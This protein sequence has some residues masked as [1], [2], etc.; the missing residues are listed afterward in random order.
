MENNQ[1][2]D[3]FIEESQEHIENLNS[4][5]LLLENDPENRQ[6]IDEI[7]RSAHTLKGMAATMGFE[8]MNKL[9][10]KME[11]VLQEVKNGQLHISHAIMDIL[12]KCVDTLSEMLDSISQTGEDNVPIEELIFLLSGVSSK[13]GN[14]EN[15][16]QK[17]NNASGSDTLL[18]V[19]E[20]DIIREAAKD[21]YKAYKITVHID[22]GCVMKSARAFIIFN[23]LDEIGDIINSSP[24]V[25]DIE[26]EKFEDSF[27]VHIITK[28]DKESIEKRLLSIAEVNNV[29]VELINIDLNKEGERFVKEVSSSQSQSFENI[30]KSQ[31]NNKTSKSV[32]V[33]ID[34][35]DN[36]MNLVSELIIIKTRLEGLEADNKN[37]ETVSA[38]EYL[39]RI[40]TNLHDAVMKVRMVPVERVFNRF[41]R[42]VRDLSY[43]LG[44]KIVLNMYGQDTEVDRTVIDEI[45][46]PLVHLIRNSIDHGIEIPQERL[47]KGKPEQGTINLR[48]YHEGNNVIIEVSDD[49][50]G[51][52]IEKVKA[53]AVEKGIYTAEQVNDL[54]KDKILDLLFRPGFSTTD[55]VTD[56]S[57]RGVG[58]DV[59][60]NKIESLNGSIE[61]LSEINKGTKFIIKLP[62]TLAIIQALLVKV[63][64]E[65]FAIPLNSI[66]EIVHKKEEEI[67]NVQGK[68]VVL[69]RGK[70]IPI[71]RLNEVL[72][73]KKISNN[74]N[75]VCVII[76]KGENLA[77]CTVDELIG[78][79]EIV[80][81]PLGKYLSNVKVIAGATIL[82]DGQVALIVDANNL[83]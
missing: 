59:V 37:S 32:R 22:K 64:D 6:V 23:S 62:F 3:I 18:N 20:E 50:R 58:L 63:G 76:K 46:D 17:E 41:P 79:Q 14:K 2:I 45:G 16:V 5:L 25:E 61:I 54:S 49:G 65:K 10:H 28:E 67:H 12:F 80:I 70:V 44:K 60:K 35:L 77:C 13:S 39:E 11:D 47:Q 82:G 33:D 27:T 75:L 74:G 4:N 40:T 19:Y 51:I 31:S 34:R 8:N 66:S 69:F 21:N 83:F 7:F 15:I 55:K 38:I 81:K 48:A 52:D 42:M 26:D 43:E 1:Y 57:G 24:S 78:Q 30:K 9:A 72:E 53:K 68:E 36:L 71:I 29:E 73:T 56:I